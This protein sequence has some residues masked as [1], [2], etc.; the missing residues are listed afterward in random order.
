MIKY[1]KTFEEKLKIKVD[2]D[3]D[4]SFAKADGGKEY[5]LPDHTKIEADAM[6]ANDQISK[7]EYDA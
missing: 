1:Y 5:E 2:F 6:I 4:K 7:E 3:N